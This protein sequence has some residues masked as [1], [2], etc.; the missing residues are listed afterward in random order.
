MDERTHHY[1]ATHA[2]DLVARYE[3]AGAAVAKYLRLAFA[4][5]DRVLDVGAGTGR[6][7]AFLAGEGVEA[8]GVEPVDAMR[9]AAVERHPALASR[10]LAGGL[11]N[12]PAID[13][14]GGPFDGV[15]CSAVLQ[16]LERGKLFEA[17]F[18]L[19]D[20]LRANGRLLVSVPTPPGEGEGPFREAS[21]CMHNGVSADELDLLLARVGF[22]LTGRWDDADALGRAGRRW[23][24][25]LF[26]LERAGGGVGSARPLDLVQGVLAR[27]RKVA[28]YKLA[29]IRA[30]TDI[31]LTQP[32]RARWRGGD[33]VVPVA[34]VA[35]RWIGYYWQ[36]LGHEPFL[37]QLQGDW[38]KQGHSL[39]F[40]GP[41]LALIASY[42][43]TG[44]LAGFTVDVRGGMLSAEREGIHRELLRRLERAIV[45]GPVKHAGGGRG[46]GQLFRHA[47]GEIVVSGGLWK[48]LCLTGYWIRDALMLRWAELVARLSKGNVE[49]A[50][51]VGVLLS[52][53]DPA[54][55]QAVA[56][57]LF[58]ARPD[59]RCVW[60]D[61]PLRAGNL[62]IDHVIPF[63]LWRNN[64][65]WNL[66]PA[67]RKVN[68]RKSDALPSAGLLRRRRDAIL[69]CWEVGRTA[70]GP[71]F[72]READALVGRPTWDPPALFDV[73]TEC[74]EVTA[75]QTG[76]L[77]F[78]G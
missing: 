56:R 54:R 3:R 5:G 62:D 37:P 74:V 44:D 45:E 26:T 64:D 75:L 66:L 42:R 10:I 2:R 14:I 36:L 50:R 22:R 52:G 76:S 9:A 11:P 23:A 38:D 77:R 65:L 63:A 70:M 69:R 15:L 33:A 47:R 61:A 49:P 13:A 24:T 19:R 21:G 27:D 30:L 7:V 78:D 48:E 57:E 25:M 68:G 34:A 1:Y 71:R 28:T 40:A 43:T 46:K 67:D 18:G 32:H 41:L 8:Y 58:A 73:V 51:V 6:D 17:A 59:L 35:E 72:R 16:H 12:L 20:V 4:A 60:S 29:L 55:E 53:P 31:A 39:L